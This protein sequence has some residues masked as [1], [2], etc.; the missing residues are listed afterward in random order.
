ML[1]FPLIVAN[2]IENM[3]IEEAAR[4][5]PQEWRYRQVRMRERRTRA[6]LL[7]NIL[8]TIFEDLRP[9]V[10]LPPERKWNDVL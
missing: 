1:G 3:R 8:A 6:K 2:E 9:G 7:A 10:N 4:R 5:A